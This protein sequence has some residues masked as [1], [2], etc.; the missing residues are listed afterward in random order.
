MPDEVELV[1]EVIRVDIK[2]MPMYVVALHRL[3][4]LKK[5]SNYLPTARVVHFDLNSAQFEKLGHKWVDMANVRSIQVLYR[6]EDR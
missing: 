6:K 2:V 5:F 4:V 1:N 3:A